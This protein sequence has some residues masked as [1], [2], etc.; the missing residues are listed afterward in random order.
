M[1][2]ALLF[3]PVAAFF[4]TLIWAA[5]LGDTVYY[6]IENNMIEEWIICIQIYLISIIL[7]KLSGN[8]ENKKK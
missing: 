5:M 8:R 4:I 3:T 1:L 6:I 2:I 7:F